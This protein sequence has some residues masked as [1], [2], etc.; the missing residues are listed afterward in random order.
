MMD[1]RVGR[2]RISVA[3]VTE[4][5]EL[6]SQVRDTLVNARLAALKPRQG[7]YH[8]RFRRAAAGRQTR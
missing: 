6:A 8:R 1:P 5:A 4:Q 3:D 7:G 2:E